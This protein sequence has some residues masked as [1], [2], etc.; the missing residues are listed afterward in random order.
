[1]KHFVNTQLTSN[2]I[3]NKILIANLH[4]HD[5]IDVEHPENGTIRRRCVTVVLDEFEQGRLT[6]EECYFVFDTQFH[7]SDKILS[8]SAFDAI[9][10]IQ[11]NYRLDLLVQH[12]SYE[13]RS[14]L[15]RRGKCVDILKSDSDIEVRRTLAQYGYGLDTLV[16]DES[17]SVRQTVAS[18][19]YR[20]DLLVNDISAIIRRTVASSGYASNLF[21]HDELSVIRKAAKKS[22]IKRLVF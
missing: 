14:E 20:L 9:A 10:L 22:Q 8:M 18:H 16:H 1:M 3:V 7:L 21:E 4:E 19:H 15:A 2:S 17:T 13:V 5:I 6:K 12:S 11:T